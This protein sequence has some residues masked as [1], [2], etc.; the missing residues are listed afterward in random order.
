ME[1]K[2]GKERERLF[3]DGFLININT[4]VHSVEGMLCFIKP[5]DFGPN[6]LLQE[7]VSGLHVVLKHYR[8]AHLGKW[9]GQCVGSKVDHHIQPFKDSCKVQRTCTIL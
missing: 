3:A 1:Q 8:R 6:A 9:V 4:S 5:F 7:I 2:R